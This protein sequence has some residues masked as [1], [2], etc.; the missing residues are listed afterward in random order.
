MQARCPAPVAKTT[1]ACLKGSLSTGC[2]KSNGFKAAAFLSRTSRYPRACASPIAPA[3]CGG[4]MIL[5]DSSGSLPTGGCGR[6]GSWY[7]QDPRLLYLLV[8]LL[9]W[10]QP[11]FLYSTPEK[12]GRRPARLGHDG[13]ALTDTASPSCPFLIIE[14]RMIRPRQIA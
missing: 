8:G 5:C 1:G 11:W 10:I 4:G 6:R 7:P 3:L 13:S 14:M 12:R 2:G 9:A